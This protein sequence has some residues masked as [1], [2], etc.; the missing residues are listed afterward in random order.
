MYKTSKREFKHFRKQ[1]NTSCYIN[2]WENW[3]ETNHFDKFM[4]LLFGA[5]FVIQKDSIR[6]NEH[7][8]YGCIIIVWHRSHAEN[9]FEC[10]HFC[11][12]QFLICHSTFKHQTSNSNFDAIHV[13]TV[14]IH[15][16]LCM[17]MHWAKI[18]LQFFIKPEINW[19]WK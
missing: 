13:D 8:T 17:F 6:S 16:H 11:V 12:E 19:K 4:L 10:F 14:P 15:R 18:L 5:L 2:A 7:C 9:L 1:E 3:H